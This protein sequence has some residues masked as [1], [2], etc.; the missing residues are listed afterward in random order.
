M[1]KRFV[2][3]VLWTFLSCG[4]GSL[5]RSPDFGS[6]QSD[7]L[8]DGNG[9][10]INHSNTGDLTRYDGWNHQIATDSG[11]SKRHAENSMPSTNGS[12]SSGHSMPPD[13]FRLR[14][15]CGLE[16]QTRIAGGRDAIWRRWG[17]VAGI[18]YSDTHE[19]YCGGALISNRYVIT[20]ARCTD[21]KALSD[22]KVLLGGDGLNITTCRIFNVSRLRQHPGYK[23]DTFE[24]DI[25]ILRLKWPARFNENIRP[26]CL[27]T[28]RDE[29][30]FG[31]KAYVAGWGDLVYGGPSSPTLQEAELIIWN[32]TDCQG[33]FPQPITNVFLCAGNRT[34]GVDSCQGDSG[35][36]LIVKSQRQWYLVGVVSWGV[37]CATQGMPGVYT[38]VTEFLDYIYQHAI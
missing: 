12:S 32:N 16:S 9:E 26:I 28:S 6:W 23:R 37:G 5:R 13:L 15:R 22:M 36:P 30:F 35:G 24:N 21:G 1:W 31:Q 34:E 17:W 29:T 8:G 25:A 27:P 11:R 33:V 18:L 19:K 7:D 3:A 38:R 10:L 4:N 20:A 2:C 14:R